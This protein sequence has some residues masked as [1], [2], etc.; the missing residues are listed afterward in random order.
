MK[1]SAED[2]TIKKLLSVC[3]IC[4]GGPKDLADNHDKYLYGTERK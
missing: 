2:E 4:K 3:G 1:T